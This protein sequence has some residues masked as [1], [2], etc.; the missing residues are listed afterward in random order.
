VRILGC[1]LGPGTVRGVVVGREGRTAAVHGFFERPIPDGDVAGA[2]RELIAVAQ[3]SDVAMALSPPDVSITRLPGQE[4]VFGREREKTARFRAE[5]LGFE[6]SD[7]VRVVDGRSKVSYIAAAR[8]T[9]VASV[10]AT[11]REAGARLRLLDHEAYAWSAV[12]PPDAQALVL[13]D[14]EKVRLV[15]LGREQVQLGVFAWMNDGVAQ[16]AESIAASIAD[17]FIEASKVGFADVN[18]VAVDDAGDR[19]A[20][21]LASKLP[22]GRVV[23]FVLAIDPSK[24]AWALACGI[25]SRAVRGGGRRLLVNFGERHSELA[26]LLSLTR[27]RLDFSDVAVVATGVMMSLGLVAWRAESLHELSS[28]AVMLEKKMTEARAHATEIDRMTQNVAVARSIV[29]TVDATRRSGPLTAREVA[30]IS[31]RLRAGTSATSLVADPNG[32]SLAGHAGGYGDVAGLIGS[33]AEDGFAPSVNGASVSN[34][35]LG[36][37]VVLQ[38]A[39]RQ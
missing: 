4:H 19:I 34:G 22:V 20:S 15:V 27:S 12:I 25:A 18:V 32:W 36:Y 35:R 3:T 5:A 26:A 13:V 37:T 11:C 17:A 29:T 23:P 31:G 14:D 30:A 28:R 16:S 21:L 9:A 6:P 1:A 2:L 38:R 8:R 33:L 24:T 10:A 7:S 39:V